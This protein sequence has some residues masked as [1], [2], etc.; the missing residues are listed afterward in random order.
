MLTK[1]RL[2]AQRNYCLMY[3]FREFAGG[4]NDESTDVPA[5]SLHQPVKNRKNKSC[6][7]SCAGLCQPHD[8][9]PCHDR[10]NRLCLNG[11][12][13]LVPVLFY[14][15]GHERVKCKILKFQKN[16]FWLSPSS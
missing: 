8:I 13:L 5:T 15:C 12:G 2:A 11:S 9:P 4:C 1:A 10:R 14:P 7:L 16:S 3:L 6:S